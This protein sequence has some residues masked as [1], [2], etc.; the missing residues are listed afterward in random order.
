MTKSLVGTLGIT[1][2]G[3]LMGITGT[4]WTSDISTLEEFK[5]SF[6]QIEDTEVTSA[7]DT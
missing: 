4:C 5:T 2:G 7:R 6:H 3:L 1:I